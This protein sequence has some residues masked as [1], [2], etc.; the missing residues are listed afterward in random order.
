MG[1]R[2]G[3]GKDRNGTLLIH[4]RISNSMPVIQADHRR[5]HQAEYW[6]WSY[7]A[8]LTS[9]ATAG[10][11]IVATDAALG[12]PE[13]KLHTFFRTG[14]TGLG[15]INLKLYENANAVAGGDPETG[16][17]H[18]RSVNEFGGIPIYFL[19]DPNAAFS[20][21]SGETTLFDVLAPPLSPYESKEWILGNEN[22]GAGGSGIYY[23]EIGNL[24][25]SETI[26]F[27]INVSYYVDDFFHSPGS[28]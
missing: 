18:T 24:N 8:T 25:P 1:A 9:F 17:L 27:S 21:G 3:Q 12:A 19:F 22:I 11:M 28:P 6:T 15:G 5:I 4:D 26:F 20:P 14:H 13:R 7:A 23:F 16:R 2:S 10:F